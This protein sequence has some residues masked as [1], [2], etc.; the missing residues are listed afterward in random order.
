M[1]QELGGYVGY[2][3]TPLKELQ[4][5]RLSII[6]EMEVQAE[7]VA[8]TKKEQQEQQRKLERMKQQQRG[9]Y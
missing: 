9:R 4:E 3:Q 5:C 6:A 8:K 2:Q 1:Y 7:E